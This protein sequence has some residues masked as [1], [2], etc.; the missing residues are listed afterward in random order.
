MP[1]SA[2]SSLERLHLQDTRRKKRKSLEKLGGIEISPV[3][4]HCGASNFLWRDL[5]CTLQNLA[6]SMSKHNPM[7][8]RYSMGFKTWLDHSFVA[9]LCSGLHRKAHLQ[10]RL[11]SAFSW[12]LRW[13]D[14]CM[15]G[16]PVVASKA[17][18]WPRTVTNAEACIS[19]SFAFV[20]VHS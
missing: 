11:S 19:T 20:F 7:T 16:P 8:A 17:T 2:F 5:W 1:V 12:W 9:R 14:R 3:C 10:R 15:Q 18:Y 13:A 4:W 6:F